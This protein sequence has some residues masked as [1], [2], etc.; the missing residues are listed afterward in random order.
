VT[1]HRKAREPEISFQAG[2]RCKS[3]PTTARPLMVVRISPSESATGDCRGGT[4]RKTAQ[5]RTKPGPESRGRAEGPV[6]ADNDP[7]GELKV[8]GHFC[9]RITCR[10]RRWFGHRL[11]RFERWVARGIMHRATGRITFGR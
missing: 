11:W 8:A 6:H 10:I 5:S 3:F 4:G 1:V 7:R 9:G 2:V